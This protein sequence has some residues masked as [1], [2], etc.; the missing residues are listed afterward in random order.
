MTGG[1][2]T[3]K[4]RIALEV[5]ATRDAAR[6]MKL[7]SVKQV[8]NIT[9]YSFKGKD[10]A[11]EALQTP[12]NGVETGLL[13]GNKRLAIVGDG[14]IDLMLSMVWYRGAESKGEQIL[15]HNSLS[16]HESYTRELT[17]FLPEVW[18]SIRSRQSCNRN[19]AIV[20]KKLGLDKLIVENPRKE[21]GVSDYEIATAV[22]AVIG[23]VWLDSGMDLVLMKDLL[24]RMGIE[25]SFMK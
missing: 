2:Q 7:P 20:G 11:W 3:K 23:A 24:V 18:C 17:I 21:P 15:G 25:D 8:E 13:D 6:A 1:T 16:L 4:L 22:E 5:Q 14:V 9:R 10:I 19:L 12:N